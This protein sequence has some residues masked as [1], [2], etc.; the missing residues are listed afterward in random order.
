MLETDIA[1]LL[2]KTPPAHEGGLLEPVLPKACLM[3]GF[4]SYT[5][6]YVELL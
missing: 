5:C 4:R 1:T 3:V 2:D 6:F